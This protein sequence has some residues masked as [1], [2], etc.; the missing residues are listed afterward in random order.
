MYKMASFCKRGA[1]MMKSSLIRI[2][3]T[4]ILLV[5]LIPNFA[6]AETKTFIKEYTYQASEVDSKVSSRVLALEQVKRLLLE[7]LGTYLESHTEIV[8][9]QLK[10]DQI[11]ALTAGIVQTQILKE[12]WDGERY[13]VQAKIEADPAKVAKDV[14]ALRKDSQK[15]K[16]LED[17]RKKADELSKEVER[18][19]KELEISKKDQTKI[20]RY[21]DAIKEI[22]GTDF[23]EKGLSLAR[24]EKR[25]DAIDAFTKA[26]QLNPKYAVAFSVRGLTY[27]ELGN[28]KQAMN[29]LNKAIELDPKDPRIYASRGSVY[30]KSGNHQ[31]SIED[32]N[33]AI[34]LDPK[35]AAAYYDRGLTYS[36]LGNYQRSI[37]NYNK[38]I[39]LDPKLAAVAYFSRGLDYFELGNCDQAIKDYNKAIELNTK[40]A[41]AY[42]NRGLAYG[43]LGN[44]N[45]AIQDLSRAIELN[46]KLIEAYLSRGDV[47]DLAL[48][49]YKKAMKDYNRAIEINPEYAEAY[50]S[51]GKSYSRHGNEERAIQDI[52]VAARLG[53]QEAQD[54]LKKN[55]IAWAPEGV[56]SATNPD[57]SPQKPEKNG[58][59]S[60]SVTRPDKTHQKPATDVDDPYKGIRGIVLKNG[61]VIEGKIVSWDPD[62]VRI[63]TKDGK[64]LSYDFKKEVQTFITK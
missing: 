1:T 47:Y 63:R 45:Q 2:N 54:F 3:L 38:V 46:P 20:A 13:W 34:E 43:R 35:L 16:E 64:V 52:K 15:S 58:E 39:H 27:A 49:N 31:R 7:E 62:I 11:T 9:F 60:S 17:V 55:G 4:F 44:Y 29:D 61:D 36:R 22:S 25:E 28:Y 56:P 48:R 30:L 40:Y 41:E 12:K 23:V 53:H 37:E 33:K 5:L 8:N 6:S 50:Y 14:D 10:R 18:L 19:R 59:S 57:R 21:D 26:I 51:R 32:Y 42:G 24:A